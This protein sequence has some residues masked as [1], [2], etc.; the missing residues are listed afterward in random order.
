MISMSRSEQIFVLL[1][2]IISVGSYV[3]IFSIETPG[4]VSGWGLVALGVGNAAL[5]ALL[6]VLF[7][8]LY[9]GYT[10]KQKPKNPGG[11]QGE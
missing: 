4:H 9:Q 1:M 10:Q 2:A 5:V 8:R 3:Y 6:A 11:A 7:N